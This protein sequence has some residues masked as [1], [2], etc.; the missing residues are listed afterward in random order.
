[1]FS[2]PLSALADITFSWALYEDEVATHLRLMS[3]GSQGANIRIEEIAKDV[4]TITIPNPVDGENHTYYLIGIQK[5][6]QGEVIAYSDPSNVLAWCARCPPQINSVTEVE[7]PPMN[8][9]RQQ[10]KKGVTEIK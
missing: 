8:S 2:V 7:I 1:M 9:P 5:N 6:E 4:T 3:D 10:T